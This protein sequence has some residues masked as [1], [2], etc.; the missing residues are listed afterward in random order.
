MKWRHE[1]CNKKGMALLGTLPGVAMVME[2]ENSASA[3]WARGS[4]LSS[5]L[6]LFSLLFSLALPPF[7]LPAVSPFPLQ[8][9]S[10]FLFLSN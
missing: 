4:I 1:H 6:P 3:I 2:L 10:L 7:L 5:L 8:L 9:V